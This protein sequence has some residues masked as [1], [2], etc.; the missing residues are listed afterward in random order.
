MGFWR[1]GDDLERELRA[2]RPEPRREL[3]DD[4]ARMVAG[5]PRSAGRRLRFGV[6]VALT[7]AMLGVLGAFGGLSYAA[8][9]VTHAVHSAVHVVV[10]TKAATPSTAVSSATAQYRV[11]VCFHGFTL[12]VDSHF[13]RLLEALGAKPGACKRRGRGR[14]RGFGGFT[15][16]TKKAVMCFSGKNTVVAKAEEKPLEKLHFKAGYCKK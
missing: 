16:S 6:A 3:V 14:G 5:R 15:P 10:P 1:R 13:L 7:A 11:T 8:G 9:G 4:I 2:H 12:Q